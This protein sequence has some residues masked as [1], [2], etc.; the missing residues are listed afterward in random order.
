MKSCGAG[1]TAQRSIGPCLTLASVSLGHT[2][3]NMRWIS[4]HWLRRPLAALIAVWFV[5]VMVE[6]AALHS[7]P[8][9]GGHAAAEGAGGSSGGHGA[10][11][12]HAN[13]GSSAPA[14]G[15]HAACTCPG[16]CTAAG[17]GVAVPSAMPGVVAAPVLQAPARVRITVVRATAPADFVLPF[18]N[19][20]PRIS[21]PA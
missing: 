15:H 4:R 1:S 3:G 12:L 2:F 11:S 9:H 18:A 21:R 5:L 8:V 13:H 7:C 20:P 19:G 6:P 16:D 10:G 14:P 17:V